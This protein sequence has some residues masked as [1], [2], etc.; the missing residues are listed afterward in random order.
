[1]ADTPTYFYDTE[2]EWQGGQVLAIAASAPPELTGREGVW[3]PEHLWVASINSCF[4]LAFLAIAEFS[5]IALVSFSSS[6]KGKLEKV[7]GAAYQV[8]KIIVKLE[9][10]SHQ[11]RIYRVCR[12]SWKKP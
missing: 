1:M 4:M 2:I 7:A 3:S 11:S 10:L 12:V 8:T 9:W 6:A 5:K